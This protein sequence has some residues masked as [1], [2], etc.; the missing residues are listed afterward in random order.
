MKQQVTYRQATIEDA[1]SMTRLWRQFWPEPPTY[2]AR[3]QTK[4]ESDSDLIVVAENDH[5]FGTIIGGNDGW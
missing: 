5:E 2:E 3:L 4:I 1:E